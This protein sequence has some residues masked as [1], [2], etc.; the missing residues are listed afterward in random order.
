MNRHA[1]TISSHLKGQDYEGG[2]ED[3]VVVNNSADNTDEVASKLADKVL[4]LEKGGAWRA[5]NHGVEHASGEVVLF[6]D[7]DTLPPTNWISYR[8]ELIFSI[9]FW[10]FSIEF[11]YDTRK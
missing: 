6:I 7:A 9:A 8:I 4:V 1:C 3:I 10:I 11:A 5:R 2:Y